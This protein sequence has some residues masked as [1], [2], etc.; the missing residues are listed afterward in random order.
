MSAV[1]PPMACQEGGDWEQ[2]LYSRE[3]IRENSSLPS[4]VKPS[5][6]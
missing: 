5:R 1:E 4:P 2:A 3:P 6:R